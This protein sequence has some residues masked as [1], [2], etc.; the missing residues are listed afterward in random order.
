[1]TIQDII[2][3]HH[4]K[5]DKY[6]EFYHEFDNILINDIENYICSSLFNDIK[7]ELENE[8]WGDFEIDNGFA[9]QTPGQEPDPYN[10]DTNHITHNV[11]PPNT[12]L[13]YSGDC[14]S[15]FAESEAN[16]DKAMQIQNE[17]HIFKFNNNDLKNVYNAQNTE[18]VGLE[19]IVNSSSGK[20]VKVYPI[21]AGS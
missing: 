3:Q 19:F 1:M 11:V 6:N 5:H 4:V 15:T 14:A 12:N 20:V 18:I 21:F 17:K 7:Q 9:Y 10:R 2:K 16:A 13:M 8:Q